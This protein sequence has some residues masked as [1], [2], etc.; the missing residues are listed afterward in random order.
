M[1][2]YRSVIP[3]ELGRLVIP[4]ILPRSAYWALVHCSGGAVFSREKIRCQMGPPIDLVEKKKGNWG[5]K[6]LPIGVITPHL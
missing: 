1:L 2:D 5:E 3:L 4:S 6:T